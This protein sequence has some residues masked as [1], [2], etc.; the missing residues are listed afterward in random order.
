MTACLM[1][2]RIDA[3]VSLARHL[4]VCRKIPPS[5][6]ISYA[7]EKPDSTIHLRIPTPEDMEEIAALLS[8]S[9]T[10][11]DTILLDGKCPCV[12]QDLLLEL[13][14]Y[15]LPKLS[16][17]IFTKNTGDLGAGKTCFSRGFIRARTGFEGRITS[18]TYLLSNTYLA[19][20]DGMNSEDSVK[21]HHLDLYRLNGTREELMPLDLDSVFTEGIAIIEWPERLVDKPEERLDITL[22]ID[23]TE[24]ASSSM[25]DE[26]SRIMRLVPYGNRWMERLKLYEFEGFFDDL[27]IEK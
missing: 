11:G 18:P 15:P 1:I 16:T 12:L 8:V 10:P 25:D 26:R 20:D 4:S 3:F 24:D 2:R 22:T 5:R 9:T 19:V 21:V 6:M 23:P 17:F 13:D 27:M 14:P 7:T